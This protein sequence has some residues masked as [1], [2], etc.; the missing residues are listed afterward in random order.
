MVP[1][2]FRS[3]RPGNAPAIT[4]APEYGFSTSAFP[5]SIG[6]DNAPFGCATIAW[7]RSPFTK[8]S[9][10]IARPRS[11]K[12]RSDIRV[13]ARRQLEVGEPARRGAVLADDRRRGQ[14]EGDMSGTVTR[15][16]LLRMG[17]P[18]RQGLRKLRI[19]IVGQRTEGDESRRRRARRGLGERTRAEHPRGAVG[20]DGQRRIV[21]A[22]ARIRVRAAPRKRL[23]QRDRHERAGRVEM[24]EVDFGCPADQE[25]DSRVRIG[26]GYPEEIAH[27]A[28]VEHHPALGGRRSSRVLAGGT[29]RRD[30]SGRHPVRRSRLLSAAAGTCA[31]TEHERGQS[32]CV[33]AELH[34]LSTTLGDSCRFPRVSPGWSLRQQ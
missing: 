33:P 16:H 14:C 11:A 23:G 27:V 26:N 2:R 5:T 15:Q 22:E 18:S 32:E 7:V 34:S 13:G 19:M 3:V 9:I 29:S 12:Y 30:A 31:H 25:P 20:I 28:V 6:A 21:L 4:A 24:V 8:L 17:T 10:P 1:S